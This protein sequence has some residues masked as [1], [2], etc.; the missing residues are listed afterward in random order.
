MRCCS[1]GVIFSSSVIENAKTRVGQGAM[2][3]AGTTF[4][5]DVPPYIVATKKNTYGGVN[6]A[7]GRQHGVDE[8]VLKHI[9][10]AYRLVFNGGTSLLD[11]VIQ[12]V[13]QV[14]DGPEIQHIVEFL[15]STKLGIIAR[16]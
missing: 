8:K 9:A 4:S 3:Q 15:K 10:N 13:D 12:I 14:P 11:A 7:V 6:F 2:I 1:S 5:K 16:K